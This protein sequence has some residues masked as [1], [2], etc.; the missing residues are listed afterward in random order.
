MLRISTL[1]LLAML[2]S[3]AAIQADGPAD[4]KAMTG[5]W[6]LEKAIFMGADSTD[7]FKSTVL[8]IDGKKYSVAIG[9]QTDEGTVVLDTE[10]KPKRMTIKSTKGPNKGKNIEA[11]YELKGDTLTV[12]YALEGT[13]PPKEFKSEKETQ[14]LL[15]TYKR[16]KK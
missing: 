16:A 11:I 4:L 7:L 10:K 1:C 9:E 13:D 14:T 2:V 6:K 15:A 3:Q 12:C 8:T 5:T